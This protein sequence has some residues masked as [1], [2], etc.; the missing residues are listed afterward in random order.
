VFV[1][2]IF[3]F[4]K[5]YYL[6]ETIH[7]E[8][9]PNLQVIDKSE[10]LQIKTLYLILQKWRKKK[11]FLMWNPDFLLDLLSVM[12]TFSSTMPSLSGDDFKTFFRCH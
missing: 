11:I 6:Q 3:L 1:F 9:Q 12:V 2:D 5:V 8:E 10:N 7:K 4:G